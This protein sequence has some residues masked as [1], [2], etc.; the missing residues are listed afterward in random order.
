VQVCGVVVRRGRRRGV[1]DEVV[2]RQATLEVDVTQHAGVR[3]AFQRP[4]DRRAMDRR[5]DVC[6]RL[7]QRV[8]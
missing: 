3:Q 4:V 7:V 6:D 1:I 2:R 5:R 8:G